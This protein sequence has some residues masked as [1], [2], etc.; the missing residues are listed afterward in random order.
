MKQVE[1]RTAC[2]QVGSGARMNAA[3]VANVASPVSGLVRLRAWAGLACAALS[4]M[5]CAGAAT[6]ASEVPPMML[7]QVA[8]NTYYVQGLAAL[9]STKNQNFISNSGF[10]IAPKGVVVVDALGSPALAERLMAQIKT[11]TD[12]PIT[13]VIVTHYH[14]D[15][16]Y[17][18][19]A[20][21]AAGAVIIGQERARE[22]IYS[23][24]ATLRLQAS[25]TDLAP[26]IDD[27]T[28]IEPADQWITSST[29]MELAGATFQ[30]DL[31]GPAHTPE[32]LAVWVP[33][34][35]VLFSGDLI[36]NG[37]LP[38]VGKANS[39]HW[40]VALDQMLQY[41]AKAVVPGHGKASADPQKDIILVRDY[42][43]YLRKTMGEAANNLVP[44]EEAYDDVDWARF[45]PVPMFKFANRMNA[46]NTYLLME[47]EALKGIKE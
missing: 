5:L 35:Q 29:T 34:E 23:E 30:L 43:K 13:H 15:H 8:P 17:G 32:D 14:A 4:F 7:Q 28:R 21:K 40:I 26:W 36:F 9:G 2:A 22:Y 11:I 44:F 46:Y 19:Q 25:R 37:R 31:V 47:Q 33:S 1:Q 24:T 45:A 6:A 12:K 42:L 41:P 27:N 38:F 20:F 39:G 10:V 18:L 3:N 16:I